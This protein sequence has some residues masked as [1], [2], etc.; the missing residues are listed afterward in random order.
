MV[1][2]E[3]NDIIL[4]VKYLE[5]ELGRRPT[6]H[7]NSALYSR[8]RKYFGSWNKMMETAGYKVRYYQYP[9]IPKKLTKD[10]SYLLGLIITD[11]H[12]RSSKTHYAIYLYTSFQEEIRMIIK[13]IK[14]LFEYDA[15]IYRKKKFGFNKRFN[16]QITI[17]SRDLVNCLNKKFNMPIGNKSLIAR[18]PGIIKNSNNESI[19]SFIRGVI[20]GD[21]YLSKSI[22]HICSG[23][24]LFLIDLK[25]LLSKLSINCN[26]KIE[27]RKTCYVLNLNTYESKVLYQACYKKAEYFYPRKRDKFLTTNMFKNIG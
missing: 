2:T 9:K 22:I 25:N 12:I 10:L 17:N 19:S 18:V 21:G 11:G 14:N 15:N 7:D 6:K 23:S 26:A 20:D 8:S 13:L 3:K 1:Q 4:K 16:F 27:K 24:Y 5:K